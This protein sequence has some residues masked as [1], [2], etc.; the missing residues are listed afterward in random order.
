M[1]ADD[2]ALDEGLADTGAGP[3]GGASDAESSE[4]EKESVVSEECP[5][6]IEYEE[7]CDA[8]VAALFMSDAEDEPAA[9]A[10]MAVEAASSSGGP[11]AAHA[12]PPDPEVAPPLLRADSGPRGF[13][14]G[15]GR[16]AAI[17]FVDG[18]KLS[19]YEN[20][21]IVEAVC[22]NPTHGKCVLT[23]SLNASTGRRVEQGRPLGLMVAWL[24]KGAGL[25]SKAE[26]WSPEHW[27]SFTERCTGRAALKALAMPD[28]VALLAA[29]RAKR[30]GEASEP[31]AD[32]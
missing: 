6:D 26:H 8:D 25:P 7:M 4:E 24:A 12:A 19:L 23:R 21:M 11:P 16:A 20:R 18:G 17:V 31:E 3:M 30:P 22:R 32:P 5:P 14:M 27:P 2:A 15:Q 1:G 9:E 28:S 10:P 13:G 29:E